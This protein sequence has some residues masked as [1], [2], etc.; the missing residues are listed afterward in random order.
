MLGYARLLFISLSPGP[1]VV[2]WQRKNRRFFLC[3]FTTSG[4]GDLFQNQE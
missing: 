1:L 3:H 4:P 2:K